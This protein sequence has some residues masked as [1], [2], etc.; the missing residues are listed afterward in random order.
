MCRTIV[1]AVFSCVLLSRL[2]LSQEEIEARQIPSLADVKELDRL[3]T[4]AGEA[5]EAGKLAE[6]AELGEQ[7]FQLEKLY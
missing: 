6:A 7:V 5:R 4:A 3:S 1:F 2:A